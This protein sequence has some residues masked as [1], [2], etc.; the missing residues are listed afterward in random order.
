MPRN[1]VYAIVEGHGEAKAP[2]KGELPAVCAL[3]AKLLVDL[4]CW[5]LFPATK[6][7]PWRMFSGSDFFAK[8][9]L[10]QVVRAHKKE[11]DCAALVVLFD[12][13]INFI[14]LTT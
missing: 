6:E 5:T 1:K 9:K 8:G 7:A 11:K 14:Y 10:E 3:I 13:L 2:R 12:N 4:H